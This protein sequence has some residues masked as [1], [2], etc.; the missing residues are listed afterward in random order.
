MKQKIACLVLLFSSFQV[1]QSL[2]SVKTDTIITSPGKLII[3]FIGHGSL[4]FE[5][6][7]NVIHV[8]PFS[9]LADYS[10]L[11]KA[12][13]ALITHSHSDHFDMDALGKIRKDSTII[14]YTEECH[15]TG[16]Y[17]QPV[18]IMKNGDILEFLNIKIEAVPAYNIVQKRADGT[19]FHPKGRGN[20]YILTF[21]EKRV[22]VA[23]DT[24]NIPEMKNFG[25]IDI[26][27]IP[28]NLPYTMT[29]EL[30]ADAAK[31]IRPVILYPY[32][33]GNTD[34]SLLLS[35]LKNENGIE[36]RVRDMK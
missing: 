15:E 19:P 36:I 33:Y 18:T 29:P 35:L 31:M 34:V 26:A 9:R 27:F 30:A 24:E 22:Y 13:L 8:D 2:G 28:M 23:G 3:H 11:P 21:G 14:V 10:Q 17:S 32:H 25:K 5:F 6:N 20:G 12:D 7:G 1:F 4:I 16:K